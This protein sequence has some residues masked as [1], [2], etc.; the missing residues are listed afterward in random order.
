MRRLVVFVFA[1]SCLIA[2]CGTVL[3]VRSQTS[4]ISAQ[5]KGTATIIAPT[6]IGTARSTMPLPTG[7]GAPTL[8]I[9]SGVPRP[10]TG[11]PPTRDPNGVPSVGL[12]GIAPRNP[13]A[14]AS[15]PAYT[16]Q[17]A[18]DYVAAHPFVATKADA[19][20][21]VSVVSVQFLTTSQ[22]NSQLGLDFSYAPDRL[23]CVVGI[24]GSFSVYGPSGSTMKSTHGYEFFDAH[25][26]NYLGVNIRP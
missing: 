23:L 25:T 11:P 15:T 19:T 17:D 7:P 16:A 4:V 12:N 20:G 3:L 21:P 13:T 10:Q 18:T 8:V 14:G 9:P 5:V 1:G 22:M 26:G 6:V 24:S 2:I